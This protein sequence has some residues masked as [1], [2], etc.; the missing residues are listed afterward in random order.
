LLIGSSFVRVFSKAV[1]NNI[2]L[3]GADLVAAHYKSGGTDYV[4][5]DNS[6]RAAFHLNSTTR[7]NSGVGVPCRA[8]VKV[9]DE[10]KPFCGAFIHPDRPGWYIVILRDGTMYYEPE[11]APTNP[12]TFD[13]DS[14]FISKEDNFFPGFSTFESLSL[15]N[16]Y[17]IGGPDGAY[18]RVAEFQNTPEFKD[19]ASMHLIPYHT[20]GETT[21]VHVWL[22]YL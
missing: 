14:S 12:D 5:E 9:S 16:H 20:K 10:L 13:E 11:Y 2:V 15:P 19:A 22:A 21:I 6:L 17:V 18:L 7:I 4:A 1:N 3:L 8:M